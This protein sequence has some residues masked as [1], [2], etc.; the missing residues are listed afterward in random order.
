MSFNIAV[1]IKPVPDPNHYDKITIHPV[2]KTITREGIP[3][4]INPVD[5]NAIEAA[6]QVKEQ[7]GGKVT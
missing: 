3:T 6:L 7:W 4:I 1:C 2:H 5:K